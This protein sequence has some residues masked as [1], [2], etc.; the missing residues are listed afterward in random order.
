HRVV[1]SEDGIGEG[2][3]DPLFRRV[4]VVALEDRI[5]EGA[6]DRTA[7]ACEEFGQLLAP[8]FER[9]RSRAGPHERIEREPRDAL[10]MALRDERRPK[11]P[12]RNAV[13]QERG[14]VAG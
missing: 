6:V 4:W 3:D 8:L 13:S 7:L 14:H 11:R 1:E 5:D 9:G 12:R 2:V 10:R